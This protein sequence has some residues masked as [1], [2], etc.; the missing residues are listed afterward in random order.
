MLKCKTDPILG[1][2]VKQYY[3][4]KI[5]WEGIIIINEIIAIFAIILIIIF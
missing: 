3:P 2:E 5:C 4:E 1:K